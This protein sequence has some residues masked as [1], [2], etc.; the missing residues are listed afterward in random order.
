MYA[1]VFG[2]VTVLI[3]RMYA[4]QARYHHQKARVKEF[5]RFHRIS[6][7]LKVRIMESFDHVWKYTHG[8]DM[9]LVSEPKLRKSPFPCLNLSNA[10]CFSVCIWNKEHT[11]KRMWTFYMGCFQP[12]PT[13]AGICV[14]EWQ[15]VASWK[16]PFQECEHLDALQW[17]GE[18]ILFL[19]CKMSMA[20]RSSFMPCEKRPAP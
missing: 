18:H 6:Q 15:K 7:Y 20:K 8:I 5:I 3:N 2:N 13:P 9:P 14:N 16:L 1:S 4:T 10:L 17:C 19:W 11:V 12:I